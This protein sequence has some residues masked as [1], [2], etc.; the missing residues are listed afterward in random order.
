METNIKFLKRGKFKKIVA[1]ILLLLCIFLA[2]LPSY[3]HNNNISMSDGISSISYKPLDSKVTKDAILNNPKIYR[4]DDIKKLKIGKF[5]PIRS[6]GLM[7]KISLDSVHEENTYVLINSDYLRN[8]HIEVYVDGQKLSKS[9]PK[10]ISYTP[11]GQFAY[12]EI[13][14][15]SEL[16]DIYVY[17]DSDYKISMFN[18]PTFLIGTESQLLFNQFYQS[19]PLFIIGLI[20]LILCVFLF[21]VFYIVVIDNY[22]VVRI[23][24]GSFLLISL[25]CILC[26]PYIIFTLNKYSVIIKTF[27]AIVYM[28]ICLITFLLPII[29]TRDDKIK[30]FYVG[31]IIFSVLMII[32]IVVNTLLDNGINVS[33]LNLYNVYYI[34]VSAFSIFLNIN[35]FEDQTDSVSVFRLL[36]YV[37]LVSI[38]LMVFVYETKCS[39]DLF[40]RPFCFIVILF[41]IFVLTYIYLMFKSRTKSIVDIGNLLYEEKQVIDVINQSSKI[42]ITNINIDQTSED[43]LNSIK[44]LYP[45]CESVLILFKNSENEVSIMSKYKIDEDQKNNPVKMFKKYYKKVDRSS[46]NNYFLGNTASL[47]IRLAT[48]EALLIKITNKNNFDSIDENIGKVVSSATLVT[49]D[50]LRMYNDIYTIEKEFL[51]A[52]ANL[53]SKKSGLPEF[54]AWRNGEYCYLVAIELGISSDRAKKL[55]VASYVADIGKV[56]IADKYHDF[57]KISSED[58]QMF[59]SHTKMG[60]EILSKFK[61]ETIKIAAIIAL[62]HHEKYDGNGYLGKVGTEIP[63]EARIFILCSLFENFY[64]EI[65]RDKKELSI[66]DCINE[67]CNLLNLSVGTIIDDE[68]LKAFIKQIKAVENIIKKSK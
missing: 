53:I 21:T 6:K 41:I 52:V 16:E 12:Y 67:S 58:R 56:C 19:V 18:K 34:A 54:N 14:T 65:K 48:D 62:N 4:F 39:I 22:M 20:L 55:R 29:Y 9:Y 23:F 49:F 10:V 38:N 33:L 42:D 44:V 66:S 50:N 7:I 37:T 3:S 57:S 26:A 27:E 64:V 35:K 36:S 63:I 5:A 30:K 11:D 13:P 43:I 2:Y 40:K 24:S 46:Y 60:N 15:L 25:H 59:Y 31:N 47:S 1:L 17:I 51:L 32:F 61:G 68:I 45:E 8:Q 28:L